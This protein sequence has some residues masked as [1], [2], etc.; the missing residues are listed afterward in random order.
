MAKRELFDHRFTGPIMRALPPHRG[1]P[2]RR[3]PRRTG[4]GPGVPRGRGG[5]RDLPRGDHL[6]RDGAQGVQ[7]RG[8]PDRGRGRRPAGAGRAV[9]HPAAD[10]QGP[11]ARTSRAGK[12][13]SIRGRRSAPP[14]RRG[15]GGRDRRAAQRDVRAAG[16]RRSRTTRP[17]S[18]RPG[19]WWL[20]R[21]HGGSAPTLA[22]AAE[23]DA[24]ETRER[25]A[26]RAAQRRDDLSLCRH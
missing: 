8:G 4:G 1:R 17:R 7:D 9:G 13:I 23:L 24:A 14:D 5:G 11:P 21:R 26:R 25:A 18:S 22:E 19:R 10:D 2:R 15:P 20:P 12:T 3:R 16:P 6:A